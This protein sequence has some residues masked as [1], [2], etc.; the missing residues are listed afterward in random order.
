MPTKIEIGKRY[1]M[2]TVDAATDKKDYRGRTL[3][4]CICT[5]SGVRL[6]A[7][8][9]L[10]AGSV[11]SCGCMQ[12]KA[13][14]QFGGSKERLGWT[15]EQEAARIKKRITGAKGIYQK[16]DTYIAQIK[17]QYKTYHIGSY[18]NRDDALEARQAVVQV[19][20]QDG[21]AAAIEYIA[22]LKKARRK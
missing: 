3:Y 6:V 21:D 8:D 11:I 12:R 9:R 1:G 22:E 19:R 20:I 4:R 2:L 5:C 10:L 7:A 13:W 14:A 18:E 15:E 17:I 16:G